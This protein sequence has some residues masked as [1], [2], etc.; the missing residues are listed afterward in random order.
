MRKLKTNLGS[1]V[2]VFLLAVQGLFGW[3]QDLAGGASSLVGQDIIGGAAV[4]FKRPPRVRD[5]SGGASMML[6]KRRAPRRPTEPTEIAR[7]KPSPQPGVPETDTNP[8]ASNDEKA[9]V[10][11]NQGNTFYSVGEYAKAI[12]AFKQALT[13]KPN[14]PLTFNNLGAAYFALNQ[15]S[16]AIEAFQNA[17]KAKADDAESYF[18]LGIA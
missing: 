8:A 12:D 5:I 14:D 3:P 16:A 1:F 7:N 17:V 6:V 18:N 2:L 9:E 4:A 11:N 15:N 10:Y 13:F